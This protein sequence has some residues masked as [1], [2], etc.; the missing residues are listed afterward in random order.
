MVGCLCIY[1]DMILVWELHD[2]LVKHV[3]G[4]SRT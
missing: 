1:I 2:W 4:M 3:H